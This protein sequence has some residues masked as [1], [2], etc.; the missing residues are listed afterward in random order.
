MEYVIV[1][2]A[3]PREV[4]IDGAKVGLNIGSAGKY[5]VFMVPPGVHEVKLG[6]PGN[7]HPSAQTVVI[8]G[9]SPI[10]P[11]RVAFEKHA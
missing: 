7:L 10:N 6:G 11:L 9:T 2:S 5:N 8:D 3:E 1:E 4:F